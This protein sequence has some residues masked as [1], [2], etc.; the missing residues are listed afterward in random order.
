MPC[1]EGLLASSTANK[2]QENICSPEEYRAM[3]E[4]HTP[5]FVSDRMTLLLGSWKVLSAREHMVWSQL[6]VLSRAYKT[7]EIRISHRQIQI[8]AG[9]SEATIR[10]VLERLSEKGFIKISKKNITQFGKDYVL[11]MGI[12]KPYI[13]QVKADLDR[14]RSKNP[15][16][17]SDNKTTI[18][19]QKTTI[20]DSQKPLPES[21]VSRH[22]GNHEL[23]RIINGS[24]FKAS[25]YKPE[26]EQFIDR[27]HISVEENNIP[28]EETIYLS[29]DNKQLTEEE[30]YYAP[31]ETPSLQA[32]YQPRQHKPKDWIPSAEDFMLIGKKHAE[33]PKT[34][35]EQNRVFDI[36]D[37]MA[38]LK[39]SFQKKAFQEEGQGQSFGRFLMTAKHL[40][41]GFSAY[42]DGY[43]STELK[44][45]LPTLLT[46]LKA[47]QD[48]YASEWFPLTQGMLQQQ[49]HHYESTLAEALNKASNQTKPCLSPMV[50]VY[51]P[52]YWYKQT[53]MTVKRLR[54]PEYSIL[55]LAYHI[56][57]YVPKKP[58][59]TREEKR[60]FNLCLAIRLIKDKRWR[61]PAGLAA[62][63]EKQ[64]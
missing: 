62:M 60:R 45:F 39:F 49:Q 21:D 58:L 4:G 52:G 46:R 18:W 15:D 14:C 34:E 31:Q 16:G 7:L 38:D 54:L 42:L 61:C 20:Q 56:E 33:P 22:K 1:T 24:D 23:N 35:S 59:K 48:P 6:M 43:L 8:Q 50:A 19:P 44:P 28:L 63:I 13:S 25:A 30:A 53:V 51:L 11:Q 12:P 47:Y 32:P 26:T 55:E 9:V 2:I 40:E 57:H 17:I 10:D 36:V 27:H 41:K 5:H 64:A 37:W 29:A 3:V